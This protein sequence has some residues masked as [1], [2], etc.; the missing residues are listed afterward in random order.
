MIGERIEFRPITPMKQVSEAGCGPTSISMVL[1]GFGL[2]IGEQELIQR[3][4]PNAGLP[5]SDFSA[6][7]TQEDQVRGVVQIIEDLQL[8]RTLQVDVFDPHL[9]R[10][11]RSKE[12]RWIIRTT[13]EAAG[14][15][16]KDFYKDK[17]AR[18]WDKDGHIKGFYR[19]LE[20]LAKQNRI[21]LYTGNTSI[22][23]GYG[24][25]ISPSWLQ[26]YEGFYIELQDF[27]RQGHIIGPHGGMTR[28]VRVLDGF[29][30]GEQNCWIIDPAWQEYSTRI[31]S[32]IRIDHSGFSGDVFDYLFRVSPRKETLL[33][34]DQF[35][36][37]SF[38]ERLRSLVPSRGR[39]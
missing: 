4:F 11:T 33:N 5:A 7:V 32:L 16:V 35:N 2:E 10:F 22:I 25:F 17:E 21:S 28:H 24:S 27:V 1:S 31:S 19:A 12:N 29:R 20:D 26:E 6:G 13:P 9:D 30:S 18:E 14:R 36:P 3:Y 23:R 15:Y 38:L 39:R 37:P 8:Q 34:P